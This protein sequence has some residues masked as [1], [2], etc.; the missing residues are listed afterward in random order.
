MAD[1]VVFHTVSTVFPKRWYNSKYSFLRDI[2]SV[3]F[4]YNICGL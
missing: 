1:E 3:E 4:M 2:T